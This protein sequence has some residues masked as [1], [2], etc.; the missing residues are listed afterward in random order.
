M[1]KK[2]IIIQKN[3]RR[4]LNN[5]KLLNK[6]DN[7]SIDIVEKLLDNYIETT[8]LFDSINKNLSKKKIRNPNFPSE[9]SENIVKFAF[10]KKYKIMPSWDTCNGDLIVFN[11]KL[12]V[13]G[14]MSSGPS[15]FGPTE[16]WD[17]LYFVDCTKYKNKYFKIYEIKLSNKDKVWN[18][19]KINKND[20]Y[21]DQCLQKRRPRISF[22]L[23]NEQI[24]DF[25]KLIFEGNIKDL[26]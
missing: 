16:E 14:F 6:K 25:C 18:N 8:N 17:F 11:K 13:K 23:L 9:I 22:Q 12:E 4:F 15:S 24:K 1:D 5:K 26:Y 7:M 10:S 21:Y 20:T 2:V 19:I 3:I